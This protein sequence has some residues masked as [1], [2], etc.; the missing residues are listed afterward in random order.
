AGPLDAGFSAAGARPSSPRR[1]DELRYQDTSVVSQEF[2]G[3]LRLRRSM[4]ASGGPALRRHASSDAL[5]L[6]PP[7][8]W[9]RPPD[10]H[11]SGACHNLL[12][13]LLSHDTRAAATKGMG[14]EQDTGAVV[15]LHRPG[16]RERTNCENKRYTGLA[17]VIL[18][19]RAISTYQADLLDLGS[20]DAAA[21]ASD[22]LVPPGTQ[23]GPRHGAPRL[24]SPSAGGARHLP[25]ISA[26]PPDAE[27]HEPGL[28]LLVL[29]LHRQQPAVVHEPLPHKPNGL[30]PSGHVTANCGRP[31]AAGAADR[32]RLLP[33]P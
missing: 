19:G 21:G 11:P 9:P 29:I 31:A 1:C 30:G 25:V 6:V 33:C 32:P 16:S 26:A 23:V 14:A 17:D 13:E 18:R 4:P 8:P 24:P 7:P 3:I 28:V 2:A 12:D 27:D 22:A 20:M 5:L 15:Q 10:R